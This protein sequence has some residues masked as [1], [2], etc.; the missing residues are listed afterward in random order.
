LFVK[1]IFETSW[2]RIRTLSVFVRLLHPY[3]VFFLIIPHLGITF[4]TLTNIRTTNM[5]PGCSINLL[6]QPAW[7]ILVKF[8]ELSIIPFITLNKT[9]SFITGWN[10]SYIIYKYSVFIAVLHFIVT[11]MI[12]LKMIVKRSSL[13]IFKVLKKS[14]FIGFAY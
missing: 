7:A 12:I 5:L 11:I 10:F 1:Q 9:Q 13:M 4:Y 6:Y 8:C 3:I 14:A 2:K